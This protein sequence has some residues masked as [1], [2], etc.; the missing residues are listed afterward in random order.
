M[1]APILVAVISSTNSN[2]QSRPEI[3]A[4]CFAQIL[5]VNGKVVVDGVSLSLLSMALQVVVVSSLRSSGGRSKC[6]VAVDGSWSM[7]EFYC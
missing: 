7:V 5:V 1:N 6:F 3:L 2:F 4:L